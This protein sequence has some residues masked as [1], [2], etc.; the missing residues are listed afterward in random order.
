MNWFRRKKISAIQEELLEKR[1]LPVGMADFHRWS[2]RIIAAAELPVNDSM[3]Y[4]LAY[5]LLDMGPA[6]AF[7][8]DNYF[9][10]RLR[11]GAVNQVADFYRREIYEKKMQKVAAEKQNQAV[12][13]PHGG[14]GGKV[15]EIPRV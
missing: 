15:L 6:V 2:D 9:I 12:V 8:C 1:P 3:K 4:V 11:K 5:L 14:A 7:E 13:P 10:Q